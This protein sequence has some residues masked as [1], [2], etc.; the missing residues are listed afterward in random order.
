V[1]SEHTVRSLGGRMGSGFIFDTN[2]LHRAVPEGMFGR[3]TIVLEFHSAAKCPVIQT[4]DLPIPC[5]S[6]DQHLLSTTERLLATTAEQD[7]RSATVLVKHHARSTATVA[8]GASSQCV[9]W[10][11]QPEIGQLLMVAT[12]GQDMAIVQPSSGGTLSLQAWGGASEEF[13]AL[14][15]LPGC[16]VQWRFYSFDVM[17]VD[18]KTVWLDSPNGLSGICLLDGRLGS[19][20]FGGSNA[21]GCLV[22]AAERVGFGNF[23]MLLAFPA[24]ETGNVAAGKGERRA[25]EEER[26]QIHDRVTHLQELVHHYLS[27]SDAGMLQQVTGTLL[28]ELVARL[29]AAAAE[30]IPELQGTYLIDAVL[31]AVRFVPHELNAVG[32]HLLL[33]LL[34]ERMADKRRSL[35]SS[36]KLAATLREQWVRN[37]FLRLDYDEY[38]TTRGTGNEKLN[39]VLRMASAS[40]L[41]RTD[42]EFVMREVSHVAGDPQYALHQDTFHSAVKLWVYP[43]NL[44]LAHG[45]LHFSRG[46]HRASDGKFAWLYGRTKA[47]DLEVI[48]EPSLRFDPNWQAGTALADGLAALALEPALPVLPLPNSRQTLIIADTSGL[49][50]RGEAAPGVSRHALRPAGAVN[51]GGVMR[52]SPFRAITEWGA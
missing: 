28:V 39:E 31:S 21:G 24:K 11:P 27:K 30:P 40:S 34:A 35:V 18:S 44:T 36:P 2:T 12:K 14:T 52:L 33:V 41:P 49:H 46:S 26:L 38:T 15:V 25:A 10:T 1:Y 42:I 32:L 23:E 19:V 13:H 16:Q 37:G 7:S 51:D 6:G 8:P 5:P 47:N 3:T 50:C 20:P 17:P 45:P 9:A 29:V 48:R 22:H 4:L 43:R